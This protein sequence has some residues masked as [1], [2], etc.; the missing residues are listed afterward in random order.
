MRRN[1]LYV[2]FEALFHF[3]MNGCFFVDEV[4][5]LVH[6][7]NCIHLIYSHCSQWEQDKTKHCPARSSGMVC[8]G[9][10]GHIH[11]WTTSA[12]EHHLKGWLVCL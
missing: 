10:K 3:E 4:Q 6:T 7:T 1:V 9:H 11:S 12:S 8:N 5:G 2:E